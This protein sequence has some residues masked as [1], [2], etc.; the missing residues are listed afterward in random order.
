MLAWK[1]TPD[2]TAERFLAEAGEVRE[3]SSPA[4]VWADCNDERVRIDPDPDGSEFG[5]LSAL[6]R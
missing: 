4:K 5:M 1:R 6:T 2:V 3:R